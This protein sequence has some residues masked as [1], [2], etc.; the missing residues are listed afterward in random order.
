MRHHESSQRGFAL[1]MAVFII[2]SLASIGAYLLTVSIGQV[3][4]GAQDEQ[5]A[6]AYQAARAGI[7]WGTYRLLRDSACAASSTLALSQGFF[8]EVACQVAGQAET[9]GANSVTPYRITATGCNRSP[10]GPPLGPT[11]VERQ[12]EVTLVK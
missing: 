7:D 1:I 9:E 10:C 2:V 6:R 8:A 11:Y 4:A 5:G 12:L 3:E